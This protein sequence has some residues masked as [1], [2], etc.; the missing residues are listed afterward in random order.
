MLQLL[1]LERRYLRE[2]IE[3]DEDEQRKQDERALS[4]CEA[5]LARMPENGGDA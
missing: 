3:D 4:A 1:E 5:L 2:C